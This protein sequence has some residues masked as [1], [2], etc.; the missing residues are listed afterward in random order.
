EAARVPERASTMKPNFDDTDP[1]PTPDEL[2][3]DDG[4]VEQWLRET[5]APEPSS[6]A[7]DAV[8]ARI[9]AAVPAQP[10]KRLPQRRTWPGLAAAVL[11]VV[12]GRGL[13]MPTPQQA[14]PVSS[15]PGTDDQRRAELEAR[16]QFA[17]VARQAGE[18]TRDEAMRGTLAEATPL[19]GNEIAHLT[20]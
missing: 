8:L 3:A 14:P 13:F 6:A 1:A 15:G 10:A 12:L 9:Q 2:N 20:Q 5:P 4:V 11:L 19:F 16:D 7:W 18:R 17:A